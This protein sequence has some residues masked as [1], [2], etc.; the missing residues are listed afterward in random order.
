MSHD[1]GPQYE[2]AIRSLLSGLNGKNA[3][4]ELSIP[5]A[6]M[7]PLVAAMLADGRVEPEEIAEIDAI[8][9]VSPIFER[10]SKFENEYLIANAAILIEKHGVEDACRR[11][12]KVLS[13]DLCETAFVHAVRVIF[14]DGIVED[15]ENRIIEDM[16][17]WLE[18]EPS[19]ASMMIE[20][21]SVMQRSITAQGIDIQQ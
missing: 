9:A 16:T 2:G 18:I 21:V 12:K 5:G 11:A 15:L 14:S 3:S 6:I 7:V 13:Q 10:N 1:K 19:R 20:V 4:D 17:R 8:C